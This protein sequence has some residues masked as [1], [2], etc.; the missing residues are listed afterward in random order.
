[1][2]VTTSFTYIAITAYYSIAITN[3]LWFYEWGPT[4]GSHESILYLERKEILNILGSGLRKSVSRGL[5]SRCYKWDSFEP[6]K[7][8]VK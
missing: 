8:V 2:P 7:Q 6:E 4:T 1:M 5:V 3:S